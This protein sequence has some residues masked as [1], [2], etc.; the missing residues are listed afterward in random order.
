MGT[1]RARPVALLEKRVASVM[2]W[3]IPGVLSYLAV[4]LLLPIFQ[5][6]LRQNYLG[7]TI[8]NG[9]GYAFVMPSVLVMIARAKDVDY[10]T[11]FALC[12]LLF[13]ILG[14][15]DDSLGKSSKKGFR[16]HFT[17]RQLSTGGLKAW[18]GAASSLV[19]ASLLTNNWLELLVNGAVIALGANFLNL[20]DLR[21]GRAG[22]AFILLAL[23]SLLL[24]WV[25]LGPLFGLLCAVVGYLPW[26]LR[27]RVMMGDAGSNPLGAA[28]G[29]ATAIYSPLY[30]KIILSV[31]LLGL[32]ALS[33]RVSFSGIIESN[34]FLHFLD[35]LGQ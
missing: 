16:G 13:A 33:E 25:S 4:P 11:L 20:L 8:P 31:I 12:L 15:V 35:Q 34:R 19:I 10:A 21:P 1:S 2:W 14:G 17:E 24:R 27:R 7:E 29:L 26:D 3:L 23:P 6:Q 30:V 28:L 18:G 9:I 5:A 32:N 22:K